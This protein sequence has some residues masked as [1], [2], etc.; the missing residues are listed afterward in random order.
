[1]LHYITKSN[2][3]RQQKGHFNKKIKT[4]NIHR[5]SYKL[6]QS[7]DNRLRIEKYLSPDL[8]N[9]T[10]SKSMFRYTCTDFIATSMS[11]I[12]STYIVTTC[13]SSI[14]FAVFVVFPY[15]LEYELE[16][17]LSTSFSNACLGFPSL[18]LCYGSVTMKSQALFSYQWQSY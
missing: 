12:V 6:Y 5:C 17:S 18:H 13:I 2:S 15:S 7:W 16:S 9:A 4:C 1:M 10:L 3:T 11:S 14:L 8:Y